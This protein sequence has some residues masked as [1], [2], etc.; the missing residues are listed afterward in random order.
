MA[1]VQAET[2]VKDLQEE[3]DHM[4]RRREPLVLRNLRRIAIT[5]ANIRKLFG[6]S[7]EELFRILA[8]KLGYEV[9]T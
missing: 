8:E 1:S 9:T 6:V 2:T 4:L 7:M 3:I 5:D